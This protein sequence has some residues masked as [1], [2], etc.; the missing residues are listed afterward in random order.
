MNKVLRTAPVTYPTHLW[1]LL[2]TVPFTQHLTEFNDNSCN[3]PANWCSCLHV[4]SQRGLPESRRWKRTANRGPPDPSGLRP[5]AR[6]G[7]EKMAHKNPNALGQGDETASFGVLTQRDA[8][9]A[10]TR[11]R[12]GSPGGLLASAP[13][14]QTTSRALSTCPASKHQLVFQPS[15]GEWSPPL[16]RSLPK[17]LPPSRPAEDT[18]I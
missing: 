17:I 2:R 6:T 11:Q 9:T 16:E 12:T 5:L 1:D 7:P 13:R 14:A 4:A 18:G 15:L 8:P 3:H 10:Q